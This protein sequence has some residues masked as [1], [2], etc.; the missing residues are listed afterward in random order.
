MEV[1]LI[2]QRQPFFFFF[3]LNPLKMLQWQ[4]ALDWA[5]KCVIGMLD[6]ESS[7]DETGY[8]PLDLDCRNLSEKG[9]EGQPQKLTPHFDP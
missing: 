3:F 5:Y 7:K 2:D 4:K 1:Q 6:S 8:L 9:Q